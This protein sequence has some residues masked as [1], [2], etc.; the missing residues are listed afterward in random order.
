MNNTAL[1]LRLRKGLFV[2]AL[3]LTAL[4]GCSSGKWGFPYINPVQQGNWITE[5]NVALLQKGMTPDQVRYALGSPT[6]TDIFRPD[7]WDYPYHY[8]PGYGEPVTRNFSVWFANGVLDRW[9]G[10]K[11]PNFQPYEQKAAARTVEAT[12][13]TAEAAAS[14]VETT[15]L[16]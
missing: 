14:Q 2:S 1:F 12:A 8:Q 11:Q 9:E 5:E 3:A 15:P 4:T 6:L 7:R 10:D 16:E 13:N